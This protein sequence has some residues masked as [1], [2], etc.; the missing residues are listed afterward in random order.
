MNAVTQTETR[1]IEAAA[2][3]QAQRTQDPA[4]VHP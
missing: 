2:P 1:A 3:L 4:P